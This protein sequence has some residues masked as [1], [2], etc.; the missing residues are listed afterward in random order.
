MLTV[1]DRGS[2]LL[3]IVYLSDSAIP[4]VLETTSMTDF[5]VIRLVSVLEDGNVSER[6]RCSSIAK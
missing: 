6:M 3:I 1:L 4:L 2:L 5:Q